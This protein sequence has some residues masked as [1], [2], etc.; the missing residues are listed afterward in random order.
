MPRLILRELASDRPLPPPVAAVIRRNV[1]SFSR[2]IAEGQA[3]GTIR[4]GE[5]HL[6]AMSVAGQPMFLAL[7]G[8]ALKEAIG[9]DPADPATRSLIVEHVVTNMRAAFGSPPAAA[10]PGDAPAAA[11]REN[12]RQDRTP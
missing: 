11:G 5:P 3:D 9:A 8:R 7:V 2:I 6:F 1:E 10:R 12:P 4:P